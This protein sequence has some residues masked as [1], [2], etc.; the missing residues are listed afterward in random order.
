[1]LN[2]KDKKTTKLLLIRHGQTIGNVEQ[3]LQGQT[4]GELTDKGKEEAN[5]AAKTLKDEHIDAFFTSDLKRAIDTCRII[6]EQHNADIN[7]TPLLRERDWGDFTGMYIP[8]LKGKQWPDNVETMNDMKE[9]INT[10]LTM[11]KNN[12]QGKTVAVVGHG[13]VN[14]V[15]QAII[16]QCET[17]DIE[18]MA[19]AEIRT[20]Y[21]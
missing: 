2:D 16:K 14:K 6:A 7:T 21:I 13:I 8:D 5:T 10:F 17:Q 12:Y 20:I 4:H 15:M 19:N 18:K 1:M 11:I 3:I 9:R